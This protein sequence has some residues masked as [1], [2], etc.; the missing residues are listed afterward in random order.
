MNPSEPHDQI[1]DPQLG[2]NTASRPPNS[3]P[4][5]LQDFQFGTKLDPDIAT[6]TK[7]VAKTLQL[8][9]KM[10]QDLQI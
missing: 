2:T 4:R 7:N 3:E 6:W 10:A 9:G 5:W 8:R 1:L